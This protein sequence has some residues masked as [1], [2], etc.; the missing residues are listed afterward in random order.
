MIAN[1]WGR[2][3]GFYRQAAVWAE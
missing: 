3:V 1:D 2:T